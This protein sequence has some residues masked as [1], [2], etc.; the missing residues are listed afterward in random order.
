MKIIKIWVADYCF[1]TTCYIPVTLLWS[2]WNW[3]PP[4][5]GGGEGGGQARRVFMRRHVVVVLLGFCMFLRR[6]R[7]KCQMHDIKYGENRYLARV[8]QQKCPDNQS[9]RK[10]SESPAAQVLTQ[11]V[12]F[13]FCIQQ[14]LHCSPRRQH[15]II[16]F[17]ISTNPSVPQPLQ[18]T[19]QKNGPCSSAAIWA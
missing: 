2:I 14:Y 17:T 3:F 19:D 5:G 16:S 13:F 4:S 15:R 10:T 18:H 9:K 12:R 11:R 1:T 6:N 8:R 7:R